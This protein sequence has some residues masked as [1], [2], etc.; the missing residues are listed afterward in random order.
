MSWAE[1]IR[2]AL[3]ERDQAEK[4]SQPFAEA[5]RRLAQQTIILKERNAALLNASTSKPNQAGHTSSGGADNPVRAA[6]VASLE[7]Q[8]AQTRME[9]S[10]QYKIQSSNAQRLLALTDNLREAEERSREER[11]ELR[12]LR[13]EVEGLRERAR[14]HKEVVAEKEKQLL[15]RSLGFE[16]RPGI[17]LMAGRRTPQIL[18]DDHA[19][20]EL[21]LSQVTI[22]NENLKIDN[23]S[24]LQRWLETK[25]EVRSLTCRSRRSPV[26]DFVCLPGAGGSEDE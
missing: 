21:E 3:I 14:W 11:D 23:S 16:T 15:V 5:Y 4:A 12:R 25:N 26:N 10:E 2:A 24:L 19:S 13:H 18:Q 20:L 1:S 22:Q 17:K 8:L 6:L 7:T 9:L